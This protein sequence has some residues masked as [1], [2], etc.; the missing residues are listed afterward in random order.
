M[1]LIILY[2]RGVFRN[3]RP[4]FR[5][6]DVY[7]KYIFGVI[8]QYA[9]TL[10]K[11]NQFNPSFWISAISVSQ[12]EAI[13]DFGKIPRERL[14]WPMCLLS[15]FVNMCGRIAILLLIPAHL[16][17]AKN[18][19]LDFVLN[20]V[21]AFFIIEINDM[22][23]IKV[24]K[25]ISITLGMNSDLQSDY[26]AEYV[27]KDVNELFETFEKL[28][29][30]YE[31]NPKINEAFPKRNSTLFPRKHISQHQKVDILALLQQRIKSQR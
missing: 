24:F 15:C 13:F 9:Y 17:A 11:P 27:P 22:T 28:K 7:L 18:N 20:A 4:D 25:E 14:I 21:A 5:L 6:P 23:E 1:I 29:K 8:V 12:R 10:N 2:V 19:N 31:E 16:S 30:A 3:G 26:T